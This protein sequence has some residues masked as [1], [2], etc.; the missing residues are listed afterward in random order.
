MSLRVG[1]LGTGGI[2]ARHAAALQQVEGL[3]LVAAASRNYEAAQAFSAT[4]GG[5]AYENFDRMLGDM[6]GWIAP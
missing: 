1:L 4:H 5:T 6:T 2:A 3:E